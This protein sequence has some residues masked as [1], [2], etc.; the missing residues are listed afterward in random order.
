MVRLIEYV[1]IEFQNLKCIR[2]CCVNC[3]QELAD[4]SYVKSLKN[5]W[6]VESV[7]MDWEAKFK[8]HFRS[9]FCECSEKIGFVYQ[10]GVYHLFKR[11]IRTVY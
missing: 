10:H 7:D 2:V 5:I 1:T 4:F 6:E 11:S 8:V 9:I 3:A